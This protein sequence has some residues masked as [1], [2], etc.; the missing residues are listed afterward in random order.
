[1]IFVGIKYGIRHRDKDWYFNDVSF[2]ESIRCKITD[3]NNIND[4]IIDEYF[5]HTFD[6]DIYNIKCKLIKANIYSSISAINRAIKNGVLISCVHISIF[7]SDLYDNTVSIM[8]DELKTSEV[9]YTEY[10]YSGIIH[11]MRYE[12]PNSNLFDGTRWYRI[13]DIENNIDYHIGDV[14]KFKDYINGCIN[15]GI[16]VSRKIYYYHGIKIINYI[17]I[18][19]SKQKRRFTFNDILYNPIHH[20]DIIELINNDYDMMKDWISEVNGD[21]DFILSKE[22]L[23]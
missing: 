7:D 6:Y 15:I 14:I 5:N 11:R 3:I 2:I 16:I 12:I 22:N 1:M 18:Y 23:F 10:R 20:N 9:I 21:L 17:I 19:Y 13:E 4:D 8:N